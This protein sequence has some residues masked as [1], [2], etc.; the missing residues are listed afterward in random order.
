M[1]LPFSIIFYS[2]SSS[3]LCHVCSAVLASRDSLSRQNLPFSKRLSSMLEVCSCAILPFYNFLKFFFRLVY[4]GLSLG[5]N[6]IILGYNAGGLGF[7]ASPWPQGRGG[8]QAVFPVTG[9]PERGSVLGLVTPCLQR[10][11]WILGLLNCP[12]IIKAEQQLRS[13]TYPG[14]LRMCQMLKSSKTLIPCCAFLWFKLCICF[15]ANRQGQKRRQS[16]ICQSSLC[17][18]ILHSG[19]QENLL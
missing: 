12:V 9:A 6:E 10:E 13:K 2:F 4:C 8:E 17:K 14:R 15:G 11:S 19:K 7:P 3:L 1:F 18:P 16:N 5:E